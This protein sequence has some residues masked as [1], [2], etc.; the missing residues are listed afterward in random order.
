MNKI[1]EDQKLLI[2]KKKKCLK[3]KIQLN[4]MKILHRVR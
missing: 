3:L 2:I 1:K 4:N